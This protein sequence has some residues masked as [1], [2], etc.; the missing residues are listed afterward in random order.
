MKKA[1]VDYVIQI[2]LR[3]SRYRMGS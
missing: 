2:K 1:I 3:I